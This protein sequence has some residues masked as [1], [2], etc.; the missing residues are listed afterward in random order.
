MPAGPVPAARRGSLFPAHW[1]AGCL[2]SAAGMFINRH[3]GLNRYLVDYAMKSVLGQFASAFF[4]SSLAY[5]IAAGHSPSCRI[6]HW[7]PGLFRRAFS[8]R[9]RS[10]Y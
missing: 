9:A 6:G 10:M 8:I 7:F 5:R 1:S 3:P 2:L 4:M